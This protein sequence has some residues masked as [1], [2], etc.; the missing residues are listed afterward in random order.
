M[1]KACGV[2]RAKWAAGLMALASVAQGAT[3]VAQTS[4]PVYIPVY[5]GPVA[6]PK[7]SGER[8]AYLRCDGNPPRMSDAESFARIV[9][10][11][12]LLGLFAPRP[13]VPEPSAREFGEKGVAA[14]NGLVNE[15]ETHE[16]NTL[17]LLPL[18]L[19][20]AAHQIEAKNY[21][22]AQE[23]VALA[24][25]EAAKAGLS[26]NPYFQRSMGLSFDRIESFARVRAGDAGGARAV[27][28][29]HLDGMAYSFLPVMTAQDF[30]WAN[31]KMDA[32]E[33]RAHQIRTRLIGSAGN[34]YASRLED[35]GR[36][37]EAAA[38]RE[39]GLIRLQNLTPKGGGPGVVV[40]TAV[41][42]AMAGAWDKAQTRAQ[43]A[44]A[45][46]EAAD[47]EGKPDSE[48]SEVIEALDFYEIV[49]LARDGKLDEARRNFAARSQWGV[50]RGPVM[51]LAD[52]LRQG[53][54]PE[55][56]F[57][58]LAKN[59][60]ELWEDIRRR[61]LAQQLQGD[62]NNR[63]LFSNILTYAK[64]DDYEKLSKAVWRTDKSKLLSEKPIKDSKFYSISSASQFGI[65]PLAR[66][67][68][69]ILHAAL[70]AKAKGFKALQF[71]KTSEI[72]DFALV[73]FGN[74]G[75]ADMPAAFTIDADAVI[76][77]LRQ[78]I[79]SPEELEARERARE[80]AAAKG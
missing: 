14:C 45:K 17:R 64:I 66:V 41:S 79:P 70:M 3:A 49:L 29:S 65:S 43:E 63:T 37:A 68:G 18:I 25:G 1:R 5:R 34:N 30:A 8:S 7:N 24:R 78:V 27:S 31:R 74:A 19:A 58:A 46:L 22:A 47:A 36:F 55:Q 16:K 52:R 56:L 80:R 33:E 39:A 23:D 53:A 54:K 71:T 21:K 44:R 28:L 20:R 42:Q 57:G 59:G 13:E 48:R 11:I 40:S 38:L 73:M 50:G 51:H 35:Q 32:Q 4:V 9:G 6:P 60:D 12:T 76:A 15:G 2:G 72:N 10:A 62:T 67:D 69:L 26:A 77:E 75:D 61:V